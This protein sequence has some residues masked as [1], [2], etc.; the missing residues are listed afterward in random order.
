MVSPRD[1]SRAFMPYP[2]VPIA[3]ASDGPLAGLRFAVKDLFDVAGYPTSAGQALV[4]ALSGIKTRHAP[5]VKMLLDAGACCVG[6]TVTDELAFSLQGQNMHF[7]QPVNAAAPTRL[8]GGSSSGSAS[9]VAHGLC[10]FAL[11]TD[12]GGSIRAP[13][14]HCGLFGL[15]P[16]HGRIDLAGVHPLSPSLDAA[17]WFAQDVDTFVRVGEVLLGEVAQT[18]RVRLFAPREVWSLLAPDVADALHAAC[19][20]VEKVSGPCQAQTVLNHSLDDL[21][22]AF[23][24]IQGLEAWQSNG[25]FVTRYQPV[26]EPGVAQRLQWSSQVS[27]T[28]YDAAQTM[29]AALRQ[30]LGEWL[31]DDGVLVLP[32][33]PDVAPCVDASEASLEAYRA[34]S[35][36]MLC[37]AGLTGFP[38]ISLP[39]ARRLDAPLGLSLLAAAGQDALLIGL[40][41]QV[42]QAASV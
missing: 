32:S 18:R 15:R 27:R 3:H 39:L 1:T 7:G 12:T 34:S 22:Q 42:A 25:D 9:A 23:R 31:G 17:G 26:M 21:S 11:G 14:S 6:K 40:A 28:D 8:T 4:L 37:L 36:R 41:R 35:L 10:D 16:T 5:V 24:F 33:M 20:Q 30:H 13:A 19:S 29:R 2:E 38:Q